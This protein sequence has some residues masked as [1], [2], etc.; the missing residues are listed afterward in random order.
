MG[1][2]AS[3]SVTSDVDVVRGGIRPSRSDKTRPQTVV[4]YT[5]V[6]SGPA[7]EALSPGTLDALDGTTQYG[8]SCVRVQVSRLATRWP[9]PVRSFVQNINSIGLL[10]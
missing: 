7:R 2:C 8:R 5:R 6:S 4:S 10:V 3:S 9:L 1:V